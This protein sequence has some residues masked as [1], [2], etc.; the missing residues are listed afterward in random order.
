MEIM[1]NP[2]NVK[3]CLHRFCGDCIEKYIRVKKECPTCR[4]AIG[5]RRFLRTDKKM[6]EII[7]KL[8]PDIEK[9]Q[10]FEHSETDRNI[11]EMDLKKKSNDM[12]IEAQI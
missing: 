7:A 12:M 2:T 1:K 10:E 8:I 9:F 5:S 6:G 3:L 11:K 4:V